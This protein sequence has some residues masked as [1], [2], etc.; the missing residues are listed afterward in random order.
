MAYTADRFS[1]SCR[2]AISYRGR[3][4]DPPIAGQPCEAEEQRSHYGNT[5]AR[6]QTKSLVA[7]VLNLA[8]SKV[9]RALA[10]NERLRASL[11]PLINR[12]LGDTQR[13]V[14][15]RSGEGQGLQMLIQPQVEKFYWTGGHERHIQGALAANLSENDTFWDVGAHIGFFTLQGT[16]AVGPKGTVVAF[17]PMPDNRSRL[18][19][20][21][22][23]NGATAG[24]IGEAVGDTPGRLP[25]YSLGSSLMWTLDPLAGGIPRGEVSVGTLDGYLANMAVPDLVKIDAEGYETEVLRGG[26]K[27]I[28]LRTARFII[29]FMSDELYEDGRRLLAGYD[30]RPLGDNHWLAQPS[31]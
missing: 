17:E 24:V 6:M 5:V 30:L 10:R 8:P 2:S 3:G 22:K 16:R 7:R 31:L 9:S 26:R 1:R 21:L 12:T 13:I 14:T 20:N 18:T 28:G 19:R 23:L 29:E 11:R 27:L 25:M 4:S 15:V